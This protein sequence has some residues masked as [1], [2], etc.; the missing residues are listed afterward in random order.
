M[1]LSRRPLDQLKVDRWAC[2]ISLLLIALDPAQA[3][4]SSSAEVAAVLLAHDPAVCGCLAAALR[5]IAQGEQAPFFPPPIVV[6]MDDQLG[7][8][9]GLTSK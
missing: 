9:C 1:P 2:Q 3:R 6:D 5:A 7:T 8:P 4:T